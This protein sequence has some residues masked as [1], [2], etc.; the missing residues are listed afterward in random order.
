VSFFSCFAKNLHFV[1]ADE[2]RPIQTLCGSQL[3]RLKLSR[4]VEQK[5]FSPRC[6]CCSSFILTFG[7]H[8]RKLT[9]LTI[10]SHFELTATLL[11]YGICLANSAAVLVSS[12]GSYEISSSVSSSAITTHDETVNQAADVLCRASGIFSH[13]AQTVI[14]R[15]EAAVGIESL[16]SRPIEFTRDAA[17][18]L[19]K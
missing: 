15:W 11:S 8:F 19:S 5:S 14:P 9:L 1:R 3:Y 12:L 18:A 17:T 4:K 2:A 13:L 6:T 10:Y 16:R 7:N